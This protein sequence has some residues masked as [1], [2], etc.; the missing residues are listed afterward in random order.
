MTWSYVKVENLGAV[1]LTDLLIAAW[2]VVTPK[3][4]QSSQ[5]MSQR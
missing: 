2:R 1:E 3:R 5:Q 4:L